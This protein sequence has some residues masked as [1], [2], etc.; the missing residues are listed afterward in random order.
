MHLQKAKKHSLEIPF[1]LSFTVSLKVPN[2]LKLTFQLLRSYF[3]VWSC[4][5]SFAL[6]GSVLNMPHNLAFPSILLK[7]RTSVDVVVARTVLTVVA[8]HQG[9]PR[10][11]GLHQLG[12]PPS[13]LLCPNAFLSSSSTT[14]H[15]FL[16]F[17]C[18]QSSQIKNFL[19]NLTERTHW[20]RGFAANDLRRKTQATAYWKRWTMWDNRWLLQLTVRQWNLIFTP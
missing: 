9:A 6:R 2:H 12:W 18:P 4:S 16:L 14:P 1:V 17:S 8:G 3:G 15:D 19:F 5:S 10:S 7:F 20:H 13:A 11:I